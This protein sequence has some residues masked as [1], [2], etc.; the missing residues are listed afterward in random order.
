MRACWR[1]KSRS[2]KKTRQVR[3]SFQGAIMEEKEGS[4]FEGKSTA[5]HTDSQSLLLHGTVCSQGMLPQPP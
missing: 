2:E 4:Q 3:A 1:L 5:G